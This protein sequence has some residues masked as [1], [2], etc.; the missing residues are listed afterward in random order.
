MN[1]TRSHGDIQALIDG[2]LGPIR[3]A[4]LEQHLDQ[5]DACRA[6]ANDLRRI[7][8]LADTLDEPVPPDHV[9]LQIA[10]WRPSRLRTGSFANHC[11]SASP[12][13]SS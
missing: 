5:C 1:C 13:R 6:L 9:W 8:D 3:V 12:P 10:G 11:G 4:E 2:T 7:R